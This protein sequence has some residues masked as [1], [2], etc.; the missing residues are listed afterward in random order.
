MNIHRLQPSQWAVLLLVVAPALVWGLYQAVP[1]LSGSRGFAQLSIRTDPA[2]IV[3][4][5]GEPMPGGVLR[6]VEDGER[7][8]RFQN[9]ARAID[10]TRVI[11]LG[12][13]THVELDMVEHGGRYMHRPDA[14]PISSPRHEPEP[15]PEPATAPQDQWQAA[16]P[17][18]YPTHDTRTGTL[19]INTRPWSQVF[20]DGQLMGNTPQMNIALPPGRHDVLLRNRS[21]DIEKRITVSIQPGKTVT[22]VLN[23]G[24]GQHNPYAN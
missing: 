19:R 20:I 17:I 15:P 24:G 4:L 11:H 18:A 12:A 8:I 14:P 22:R 21:F 10:H 2:A 3:T 13:G 6:M 23:I 16:E 9:T 1:S 7:R 5:D